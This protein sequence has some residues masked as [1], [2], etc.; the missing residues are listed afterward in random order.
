MLAS[1]NV[2]DSERLNVRMDERC[3]EIAFEAVA[4]GTGKRLRHKISHR[5]WLSNGSPTSRYRQQSGSRA[6][7]DDGEQEPERSLLLTDSLAER[8]QTADQAA[9]V[10]VMDKGQRLRPQRRGSPS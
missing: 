2:Y 3:A 1:T 4:T 7:R 5:V 8:L 9:R 10:E 6:I